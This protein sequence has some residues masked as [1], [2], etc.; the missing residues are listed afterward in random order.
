[1][2]LFTQNA[3]GMAQLFG[4]KCNQIFKAVAWTFR[5][6]EQ[7]ENYRTFKS[8]PKTIN[9]NNNDYTS[10]LWNFSA[11]K[12]LKRGQGLQLSMQELSIVLFPVWNIQSI[13]NVYYL[14]HAKLGQRLLYSCLMK[15][16]IQ[17]FIANTKNHLI[18]QMKKLRLN[19]Q[20]F[21]LKVSEQITT[22][23]G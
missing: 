19:I 20:H 6:L 18:L 21:L 13:K 16:V 9:P 1:M 5:T 10:L 2:C 4:F 23:P 12:E 3:Y 22:V 8:F 14:L 17:L 7:G 11:P 15:T